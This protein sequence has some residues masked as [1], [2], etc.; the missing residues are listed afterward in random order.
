MDEQKQKILNLISDKEYVPMKAKQIAEIMCVPKD[1]YSTFQ[2]ILMELTDEYKITVNKKGN[3]SLVDHDR[4]A[5]G[6]L[7]INGRGF[8]FVKVEGSEEEIY[9]SDRNLNGAL[10][11]D[12]V[13][14]EILSDGSDKNFQKM[15]G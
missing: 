15:D 10:N 11:E 4:F 8:G 13:I 14:V 6:K 3:Y 12:E 2:N 7:Q 5:K 1:E 9:V